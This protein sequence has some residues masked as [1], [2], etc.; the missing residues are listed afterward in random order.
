[1]KLFE[2]CKTDASKI[3][4]ERPGISQ[5]C[6]FSRVALGSVLSIVGSGIEFVS[7]G[8]TVREEYP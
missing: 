1:M 7:I 3:N 4:E 6:K 5:L 2:I 8:L